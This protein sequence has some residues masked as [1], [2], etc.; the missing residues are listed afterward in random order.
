MLTFLEKTAN[1]LFEKYEDDFEHIAIV[2]P[3]K[4]AGL[5]FKEELSNLIKKPTWLPDIIGVTD[6]IESI[7]ETELIENTFN[8]LSY[9]PVIKK[10]PQFLNHLKNLVN[11]GKFYCTILMK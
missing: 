3:N 10:Q 8:Y 9:M 5:F 2:L 1:Y 4:R 6:F 11:G 7:S